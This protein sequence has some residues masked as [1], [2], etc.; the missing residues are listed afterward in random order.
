M[1]EREQS[2][3]QADVRFLDLARKLLQKPVSGAALATVADIE[4]PIAWLM[5]EI[6][7]S[8][9]AAVLRQEDIRVFLA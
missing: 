9:E 3:E 6:P 4:Y 8:E 5:E 1:L 2:L 7:I